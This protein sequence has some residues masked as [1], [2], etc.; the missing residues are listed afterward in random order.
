MDD[1]TKLLEKARKNLPQASEAAER[2]EVPLALVEPG[3]QTIVKNFSDI[4]KA[5][6]RDAKHF[7][8]FLFKE[9][10]VPGS[11]RGDEL[12]LQ[13]RLSTALINKRIQEYAKEFVFCSECGKPDTK[14]YKEGRIL[15]MKCEACGARRSLRA[16]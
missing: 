1:Y 15:M 8:K 16:I 9:L 10:A 3:R 6:R 13:G 4:V 5:L 7:A 14:S 12:L 2:F 11:I